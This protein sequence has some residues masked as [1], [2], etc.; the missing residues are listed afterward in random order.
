MS[1]YR[2]EVWEHTPPHGDVEVGSMEFDNFDAAMKKWEE[3]N[4][5]VND[6]K[7]VV[8]IALPKEKS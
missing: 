1:M 3:W 5:F 8:L 7:K 6:G 2:V 4:H